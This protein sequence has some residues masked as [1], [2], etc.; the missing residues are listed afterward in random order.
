MKKIKGPDLKMPELKVPSFI[1]DLYYDLRD[2]RLLPLVALVLVAI[3]AVPFLLS[4]GSK[5]KPVLVSPGPSSAGANASELTVVRATP[6]L[7]DYRKRFRGR[8][9]TDPF[10][11]PSS[12]P[13][14]SAAQL[15]T[16]GNNGFETSEVTSTTST[17][18]TS[19]G[20][21]VT[22]KTTKSSGG[23]TTK[24]TETETKTSGDGSGGNGGSGGQQSE[25]LT[26]YSFAIDVKIT[27]TEEEPE[28][29]KKTTKAQTR[30]EILPPAPLP[31][32]KEQAVTYMGISP[33]T[34]NP[35]LLVSDAV[36][37][38]YGEANCLSG[39]SKCQLLEVETGMPMTFVLGEGSVRIKLNILK[40]KPVATGKS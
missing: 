11:Q 17:R 36:T 9:P 33:T 19:S 2:R 4:S 37:A 10:K 7:R 26:L 8:T 39:E 20:S 23:D 24:T 18:T 21:T 29:H 35:L 38:V 31:G 12:E 40:V 3:V 34:Q 6:G 14:L 1:S 13:D 28:S 5:P 32:E 30:T 27:R 22:K 16:P 15:G 25:Q